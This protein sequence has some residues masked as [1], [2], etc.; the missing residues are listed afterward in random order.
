MAKVSY[1]FG[2]FTN[3]AIGA[4]GDKNGA[5]GDP[6]APHPLVPMAMIITI[7]AIV[8]HQW[9]ISLAILNLTSPLVI[10]EISIGAIVANGNP[11]VPMDPLAI[12]WCQWIYWRQWCLIGAS[13]DPLASMD[14]QW[15]QWIQWRH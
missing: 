15:N 2:T 12:H 8:D 9:R 13:G 6:M 14:R 4:N 7:G 11:L 5:F 10:T 3:G 1:I